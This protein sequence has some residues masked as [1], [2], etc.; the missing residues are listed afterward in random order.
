MLILTAAMA[1]VLE[2]YRAGAL[3][4][5]VTA[6]RNAATAALEAQLQTLRAGGYAHLPALGRYP[7]TPSSLPRF[8][9]VAGWLAVAP[10]PAP[11]TREVTATVTWGRST[12]HRE[13]LVMVTAKR[14]MDP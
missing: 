1:I 10:G 8:E 7:I 9:H 13:Q 14:G 11:D 6:E 2:T 12:P 4:V 5:Q 3:G